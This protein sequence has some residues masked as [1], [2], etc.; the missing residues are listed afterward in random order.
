MEGGACDVRPWI[1]VS[2]CL[3]GEQVRYNGGHS[4]SRFLTD[5]LTPYVDWVQRQRSHGVGVVRG[6]ADLDGYVVKSKSPSCGIRGL[7]RYADSGRPADRRGKGA[8]A[9][10]P[11]AADSLLPIEDEG[12]L[13]DAVLREA[14]VE[15]VFA[16][17]R[18]RA[19]FGGDWRPRDLVAFHSCHKLQILAHD[20][21]R[22][23]AAGRVV[24]GAGGRTR[25]EIETEYR[26]VFCT[27]LARKA[28]RGQSSSASLRS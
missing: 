28:T 7:P 11:M 9:E 20:P 27:A 13:N 4:R 6:V 17:A 24:A 18:L 22:Y 2:S 14:F 5:E 8:Y 21:E 1:G 10:R 16:G 25:A 23:R 26:E 12:R 3:L 15:R 19:L